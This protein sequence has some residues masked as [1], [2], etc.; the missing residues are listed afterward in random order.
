MI[1][2]FICCFIL[3]FLIGGNGKIYE[4]AGWNFVGAHTKGY[5]AKALGIAFIGDY[6]SE[7]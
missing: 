4:G 3:R 7:Y 2:F 5:N 6:R 1:A